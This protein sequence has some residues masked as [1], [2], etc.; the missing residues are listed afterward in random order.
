MCISTR[1]RWCPAGWAAVTGLALPTQR[2]HQRD[3]WKTRC[4][5][6]CP[7]RQWGVQASWA[8]MDGQ[9]SLPWG[10]QTEGHPRHCLSPVPSPSSIGTGS[11]PHTAPLLPEENTTAHPT[12][13]QGLKH[14]WAEPC[15][16]LSFRQVHVLRGPGKRPFSPCSKEVGAACRGKPVPGGAQPSLCSTG[17]GDAGD[18][19]SSHRPADTLL[20]FARDTHVHR[21]PCPGASRQPWG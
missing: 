12:E 20:P 2:G 13:F 3:G 18:A 6:L 10:L 19:A 17:S 1:N 16:K 21:L 14:V 8:P 11:M 5:G 15:E 4:P 9:P 7:E